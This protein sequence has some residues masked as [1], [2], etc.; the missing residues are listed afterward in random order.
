M[1][2]FY[3]TLPRTEGMTPE[4]SWKLGAYGALL[5]LDVPSLDGSS[6]YPFVLELRGPFPES[7]G[8]VEYVTSEPGN[9]D[10]Y[11]CAFTESGRSNFG[12]SANWRDRSKFLEKALTIARE[13][14]KVSGPVVEV[15][16][17][18]AHSARTSSALKW[19]PLV[20]L[21]I[22][23]AFAPFDSG[24]N[25][26][27]KWF[28]GWRFI[29]SAGGEYLQINVMIW[30]VQIALSIAFAVWLARFLSHK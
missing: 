27:V 2:A 10:H 12:C 19:M 5:F 17:A 30:L 22:S 23:F 28:N 15:S 1:L 8:V 13:S 6:K 25:M 24:N 7:S 4:S 29:F 14:L 18:S 11:I 16:P 3:P 9:P 21:A 20:P 26:G